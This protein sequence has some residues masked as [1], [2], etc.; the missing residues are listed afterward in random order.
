[1]S[2]TLEDAL[3]AYAKALT[4]SILRPLSLFLQSISIIHHKW[5]SRKSHPE[6]FFWTISE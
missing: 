4:L 2:L 5:S 3:R 1:M 6:M